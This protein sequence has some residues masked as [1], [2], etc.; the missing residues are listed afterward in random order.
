MFIKIENLIEVLGNPSTEKEFTLDRDVR[1]LKGTVQIR[2]NN[3]SIL[4]QYTSLDDFQI[5]LKTQDKDF[6]K[7]QGATSDN[8]IDPDSLDAFLRSD[9]M[10]AIVLKKGNIIKMKT[11]HNSAGSGALQAVPITVTLTLMYEEIQTVA[12]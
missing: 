11:Q 7:M 3:G 12:K 1:I 5:T 2:D 6:V 10:P 8:T 4:R 9:R